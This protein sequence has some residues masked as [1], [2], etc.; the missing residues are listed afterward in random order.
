M[1]S[2]RLS[3]KLSNEWTPA[4][5]MGLAL[6]FLGVRDDIVGVVD[7]VEDDDEDIYLLSTG[8]GIG[9]DEYD[10]DDDRDE[11]YCDEP[12]TSCFILSVPF[13]FLFN[14]VDDDDNDEAPNPVGDAD[15]NIISPSLK[16]ALL[17][18]SG[19]KPALLPLIKLSK[20]GGGSK[21]NGAALRC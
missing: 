9:D 5:E 1:S 7:V 4:V 11:V 19:S 8:D 10:D 15:D 21:I 2:I 20:F 17:N 3:S 6:E 18:L 14:T 16:L 13:I 12:I